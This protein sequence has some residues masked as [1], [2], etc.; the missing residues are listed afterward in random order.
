ME[1]TAS[2]TDF[3]QLAQA[4]AQQVGWAAVRWWQDSR[5][6]RFLHI[7]AIPQDVTVAEPPVI[8]LRAFLA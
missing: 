4:T 7:E 5:D 6:A 3:A 8:T 2:Q 1:Q